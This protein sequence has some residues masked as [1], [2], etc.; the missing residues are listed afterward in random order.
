LDFLK[1]SGE[2]FISQFWNKGEYAGTRGR[3]REWDMTVD[4][5]RNGSFRMELIFPYLTNGLSII[6]RSIATCLPIVS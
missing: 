3:I 2:W 6:S 1:T 5:G 4:F